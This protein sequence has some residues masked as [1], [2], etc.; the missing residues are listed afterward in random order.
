MADP[1]P[2]IM[3]D[4]EKMKGLAQHLR[5]QADKLEAQAEKL[6]GQKFGGCAPGCWNTFSTCQYVQP[7]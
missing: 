5:E 4:P 2:G 6:K 1:V 7:A 3:H